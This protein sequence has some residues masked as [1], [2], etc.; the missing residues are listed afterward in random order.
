MINFTHND[1]EVFFC[2]NRFTLSD[3][4][5]KFPNAYILKQV[6]GDLCVEATMDLI[7]ADAHWT[8]E[9]NRPL[10]IQTADCLPVMIYLPIS[11]SVLAI[12][13]GW[14]GVEQKIVSKSLMHLKVQKKDPIHVYIGP[15]IQKNSFEVDADVAK[16]IMDAH[17]LDLSLPFCEKR[18]NK[19][20]IDL[21]AL[22]I[23]EI[24]ALHLNV[25]VQLI[26][27]VDTKT[28]NEFFSYRN[29]DRGGRNY[30]I[31]IKKSALT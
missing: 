21:S 10:V 6:H 22:V 20:Y 31:I 13:A 3:L 15:H 4:N 17:N 14:R 28:D 1:Y 29:G 18:N 2:G 26:S 8:N 25:D 11:G 23:R 5:S 30:S 16:K 12:H 19:Y 9:S 7:E 24:K 27:D